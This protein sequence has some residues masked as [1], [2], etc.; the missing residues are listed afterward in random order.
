M[1]TAVTKKTEQA[2]R[3]YNDLLTTKTRNIKKIAER[4]A[5]L[6]ENF[7][8][9]LPW[10]LEEMYQ[11]HKENNLIDQMVRW[12]ENENPE[13]KEHALDFLY[14]YLNDEVKK[15]YNVRTNSTGEM[16]RVTSTWEFIVMMQLRNYLEE[17]YKNY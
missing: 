7:C 8:N 11:L 12:T 10:L 1:E 15:P 9:Q 13:S 4:Q 14:K 2:C 3:I 6:S 16:F 5:R 17:A